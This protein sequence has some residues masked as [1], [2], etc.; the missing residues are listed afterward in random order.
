MDYVTLSVDAVD[1]EGFDRSTT[2]INTRPT[3]RSPLK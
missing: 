1:S 3:L 2:Q